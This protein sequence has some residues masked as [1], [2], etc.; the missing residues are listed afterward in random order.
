M[1]F[2]TRLF[3]PRGVRRAAHP[4]RALKRAATP[5]VVRRA[6]RAAHPVSNASYAFQRSLTTKS[7]R[8]PSAQVWR[9]GACPVAHRTPDAMARCHRG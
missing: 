5:R 3:I 9:H 1:G 2:L 7:R 8:K 4:G 6:R